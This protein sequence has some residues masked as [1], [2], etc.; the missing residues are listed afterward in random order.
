MSL[1]AVIKNQETVGKTQPAVVFCLPCIPLDKKTV[2]IF[3]IA[4]CNPD[5]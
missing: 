5:F 3:K 2:L 4:L 1:L